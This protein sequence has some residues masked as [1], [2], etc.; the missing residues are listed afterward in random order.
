VQKRAI[1]WV[2]ASIIVTVGASARGNDVEWLDG[3]EPA[4]RVSTGGAARVSRGAERPL[5]VERTLPRD[6]A[7]ARGIRADAQGRHLDALREYSQA[8]SDL[9]SLSATTTD[10]A[11]CLTAWRGK[12]AWQRD[13]SEMLL[14]QEA[15]AATMPQSV[16]AH[17]NLAT[18]YHNKFLAVRAFLGRGPR[19]LWERARDEYLLAIELDDDHAPARI[20]L[21]SLY[22]QAGRLRDARV[23][24]A[25]LGRRAGEPSLA[26]QIAAFHTAA[27]ELD[28]A[29]D[30]LEAVTLRS[31]QRR[32]LV[33][34]N[35]FDALRGEARFRKLV[36]ADDGADEDC[37][38]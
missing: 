18:A 22:A 29:L 32:W 9:E 37:E 34:S 10:T 19:A 24:V 35:D 8:L 15:Y 7:Y 30:R 28:E 11:R 21:A 12:I 14:E 20:G 38:R 5:G 4:V 1:R 13:E 27:G 25:G 26:L 2:L 23:T 17:H 3:E 16:V 31:E 33:R 6:G 36:T